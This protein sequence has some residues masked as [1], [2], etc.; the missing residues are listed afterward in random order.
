MDDNRDA[1]ESLALLLEIKGHEVRMA[2][3]GPEALRLLETYR[4]HLII[5][6]IGL[7]GMNGY[8]VAKKIRE[9][10]G[11]RRVTLAALTGWGQD[12]DRRRTKEAGFDYHLLKPADHAEVEKLLTMVS[13]KI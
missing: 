5:L 4:P 6:D 8:E 9:S 10:E 11:H 7:P 2:Y 13:A 3:D 1:V 12:E